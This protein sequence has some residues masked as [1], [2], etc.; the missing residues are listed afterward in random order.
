MVVVLLLISFY[1][2]IMVFLVV[3]IFTWLTF[4][5]VAFLFCFIFYCRFFG[6]NDAF[7]F[8]FLLV[9]FIMTPFLNFVLVFILDLSFLSLLS[10]FCYR[11]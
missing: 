2:S 5:R 8:P 7:C 3:G 9:G 6:K 1:I 10:L 4:F 11:F